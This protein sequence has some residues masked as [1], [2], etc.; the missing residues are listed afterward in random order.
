MKKSKRVR[1]VKRMK[2]EVEYGWGDALVS[3]STN[4]KFLP[5]SQISS[6]KHH[7]LTLNRTKNPQN[8]TENTLRYLLQKFSKNKPHEFFA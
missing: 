1:N 8:F 5:I 2:N 4:P 3:E 7:K 6:S